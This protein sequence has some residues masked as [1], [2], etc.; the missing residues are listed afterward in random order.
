MKKILLVLLVLYLTPIFSQEKKFNLVWDKTQTYATD[1]YSLNIPS[2]S[3]SKNFS[4]DLSNGLQFIEQWVVNGF[5]DENS[6]QLT[7]VSYLPIAKED[8]KDINLSTIP[9]TLQFSLK[10]GAARSTNYAVFTLN[11]IIKEGN[12][13]KKVTGFTMKYANAST[14]NFRANN[15]QVITNSVLNSGEW[16]RFEVPRTGVYK[17]SKSFLNQMGINVSGFDPRNL[18]IYGNGGMMMPFANSANFPFDPT[19]NAIKVIGEED[20]VFNDGDYVLFYAEGPSAN[21]SDNNINT[22]INPYTDTAVYY[23]NISAGQGKR[24]QNFIQPTEV[25]SLTVD[26]FQD[27]KFH[28]V[29]ETNIIF[30]GRRW[31]GERFGVENTQTFSF[32]FPNLITTQPINL[33]AV[34]VSTSSSASSYAISVNSNVVGS[35]S[36]NATSPV[37]GVYVTGGSYQGTTTVA[38][39]AVN[40]TLDFNNQGNPSAT[41]YLDYVSVEATRSLTFSGNQFV[42]KNNL[43][44]W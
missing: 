16:F 24:I 25:P 27:Y 11:P 29:D 37:D 19:E 36:M 5:I 40:V 4:F 18:K 31:F 34:T 26:T 14:S 38:N 10:N 39:S 2:F 28:E 9:N 13:Y 12:S 3:P 21:V 44:F 17:L 35:I 42:F 7:N 43:R 15:S 41:S 23:L 30:V 20:G 33:K 1:S 22:N 32:D 8:L 6:I